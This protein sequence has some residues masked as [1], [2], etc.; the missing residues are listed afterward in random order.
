MNSSFGISSRGL[1]ALLLLSREYSMKTCL[2]GWTLILKLTNSRETNTS[3]QKAKTS[4]QHIKPENQSNK[5]VWIF[6]CPFGSQ[7]LRPFHY[8]LSALKCQVELVV[9][10]NITV[11][12]CL[13]WWVQTLW[14][15]VALN[16]TG[17]E[18]NHAKQRQLWQGVGQWSGY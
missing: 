11:C 5:T 13:S 6:F 7:H 17:G 10:C 2:G 1:T 15:P 16:W 14:A 4:E 12:W 18:D 9:K 8:L 3:Q